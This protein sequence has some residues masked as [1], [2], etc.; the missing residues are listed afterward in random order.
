[1]GPYALESVTTGKIINIM[2]SD[3]EK[4]DFVSTC[5]GN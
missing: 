1:M 3:V 4:F 2:S 5:T